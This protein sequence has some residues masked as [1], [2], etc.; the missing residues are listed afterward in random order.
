[1]SKDIDTIIVPVG[2]YHSGS[3][4]ALFVDRFWTGKNEM[5]RT[6]SPKQ[7]AIRQQFETACEQIRKARKNKRVI[8]V[9]NGDAIDGDHH[10]SSDVCTNQIDDQAQIHIELMEETKKR[11]GWQRG[12]KCYYTLG[13]DIHTGN[14]EYNI[15]DKV[16]AE[17]LPELRL[18]VNGRILHF[19]HH[20]PGAGDG[21][22]EGNPLRSWLRNNY[23]NS[24]KD[25]ERPPDVIYSAHVHNPTMGV[26]EYRNEMEF[27]I[28]YGVITPPLQIKT[29]Y[30][31]QKAPVKK[32]KVGLAYQEIKADGTICIPVFSVA[33]V[34]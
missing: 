9:H 18:P 1:L 20:G 21:A 23:Y 3:N 27:G 31:H 28:M 7:Q 24:I 33:E 5:N 34:K 25:H 15:A 22:N 17:I 4:Y 10:N 11:L 13:T 16:N 19:V 12:D 2:D 8:L 26:F 29:R 32:N 30:G 14:S 6:P